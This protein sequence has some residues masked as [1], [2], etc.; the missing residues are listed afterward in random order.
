[1]FSAFKLTSQLLRAGS[2]FANVS[3]YKNVST[4]RSGNLLV[5]NHPKVN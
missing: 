2:R 5:N 1:M 4:I 3:A